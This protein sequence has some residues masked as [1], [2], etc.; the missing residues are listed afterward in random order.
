MSRRVTTVLA[1]AFLL[2]LAPTPGWCDLAPYSQDFEELSLN[3]P[4]AL[5]G[6]GWLVYGNV[7]SSDGATWFYGYGPFP[8]P[9]DGAA[10]CAVVE[11][12][13]GVEQGTKQLSVYSD[14]ENLDHANGY[15]IESNVYQEQTIG[16]GDVGATLWFVF[17]AK[18]GNIWESTDSTA[19]AFIKTLDPANGYAMT[20]FITADMTHI[21]ETWT[22][23]ALSI[24]VTENL[25]GQILQFGFMNTATYYEP[26]GIFYDNV[27]FGPP[28]P[29]VESVSIDINPGDCPN[30]LSRKPTANIEV[31]LAY[32]LG[33]V[34]LTQVEITSLRLEG[35]APVSSEWEDETEPYTG[36]LCACFPEIGPDGDDDL[37]VEF[38]AQ[39]VV[40]AVGIKAP[41]DYVLTLTGTLTDGTL[42]EGQDCIYIGRGR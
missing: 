7:Y 3:S 26:S 40:E 39:A 38:P 34:D 19:A 23:Y 4:I 9:N 18:L 17:D 29:E 12:Q 14:Y 28:V 35:V 6:D 10:F 16:A 25:V 37:V 5:S 33:G 31:A 2:G 8:A 30:T 13:G 41:G 20:N 32:E 21:P 24:P 1:L 36:D 27:I 15:V 22:Q 42:I 11:E